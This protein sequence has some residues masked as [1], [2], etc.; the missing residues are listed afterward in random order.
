MRFSTQEKGS[1]DWEKI[2]EDKDVIEIYIV[3]QEIGDWASIRV[4]GRGFEI[5]KEIFP[6]RVEFLDTSSSPAISWATETGNI[7][8]ISIKRIKLS[9]KQLMRRGTGDTLDFLFSDSMWLFWTRAISGSV[10]RRSCCIVRIYLVFL[11][12]SSG[13]LELEWIW[14][15]LRWTYSRHDETHQDVSFEEV[16]EELNSKMTWRKNQRKNISDMARKRRAS[17][18]DSWIKEKDMWLSR[19]CHISRERNRKSSG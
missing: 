16:E 9:D 1:G 4:T 17:E 6:S 19:R 11:A 10:Y 18:Y 15:E 13:L 14:S 8:S 5:W 7:W 12:K 3:V 2:D